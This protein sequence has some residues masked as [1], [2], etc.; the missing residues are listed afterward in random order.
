MGIFLAVIVTIIFP[1]VLLFGFFVVNPREEVVIL[2]FGKYVTTL[3]T[4][5]IRW[6]HPVGR[7]LKRISTRDT[8]LDI[9][10]TTVVERNGNPILI[11]AVVVYRV[12]NSYKA[13]L[14]VESYKRFIADHVHIGRLQW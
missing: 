9:S 5:G 6:R 11:S 2:R 14:D 10:T 8:T 1:P 13:A 4:Q 7:I 12:E 3:K